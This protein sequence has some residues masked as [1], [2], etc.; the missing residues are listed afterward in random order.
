[1][2]GIT[3]ELWNLNGRPAR[4]CVGK[5]PVGK[6]YND[7]EHEM[8]YVSSY[9]DDSVPAIFDACKYVRRT[10][11]VMRQPQLFVTF[12]ERLPSSWLSMERPSLR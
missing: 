3:Q 1:M 12:L 2:L 6:I 4:C 10:M 7:R 11:S 5:I 9:N 8:Q